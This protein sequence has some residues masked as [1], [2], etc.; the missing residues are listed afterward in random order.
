MIQYENIVIK[1]EVVNLLTLYRHQEI[2]LS[3]ARANNFFAFFMEQGT[4]KTLVGLFRIL[5]LLKGGQIEEAL[6]VAPKSALGAWERDIELFNDLDAQILRDGITLI[7]YDKV[8]R[9]EAKSPYY[10][11]YGCIIL[12]EAHYIKNRTSRRSKFLLKLATMAD[13][14][15]ILTGTPISNGQLENIWS[16]YTFLDGYI[17]RGY[18]YSRIFRGSYSKFLERYCILNMYHKPSSYIHVRELQDIINEYSYRVK[19]V[20]CLDLPD[21]LP[22]EIVKVDLSEKKLYKK[23][24][25]ESA[26]L[27]YEILADNPLSRLIKLRQLCSGFIKLEDGTIIETK[28]EKLSIL[29]ELLEGFEDDKKIV[30]FAEFKYSIHK[31]EELLKKLKIKYVTLDGDQKDKTIW[32]KFQSD[33]SIRVFVG[34]YQSANAGIDLFSSDTIIYYEPTTR[35]VVLEQSRDRIHRTGQV[36]KCS[37]IHLLTKGTVEEHI[38]KSLSEYSDFSNKLFTEYMTS[39]RRSYTK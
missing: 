25:T 4:G 33:K 1:K 37:Y 13:Y 29:Q 6:I 38:Y 21:K 30:I 2:A 19:K 9:G 39:Y 11:K 17:E 16:L 24:A 22:D 7:N 32:R 15:Y 8:W 23:L 28:N 36:N 14:R 12:D 3:Y 31:I 35:S 26:I 27:E 10:K 20:E 5:D 34:Q 18:P